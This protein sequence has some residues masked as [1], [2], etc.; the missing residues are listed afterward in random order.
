[1]TSSMQVQPKFRGLL[2]QLLLLCGIVALL[3]TVAVARMGR[4]DI[5]ELPKANGSGETPELTVDLMPGSLGPNGKPQ[6][7]LKLSQL[8]GKVVLIDMFASWCEHCKEH[9]PHMV[10]LYNEYRQRGFVVLG[11]A[12][13]DRSKKDTVANVK[14]FMTR[15]KINYTVGFVTNQVVAYFADNKNHGV[16]QMVLFGPDGKMVKRDIGWNARMEK[17][18]RDAIEAQL[19]KMPPAAPAKPAVPVNKAGAKVAPRK[20]K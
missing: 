6:R 20:T 12:T 18:I 8:R 19:A 9:A 11:L 4:E 17:P 14:G 15:A 13:D 7:T 3:S 2:R 1:M 16:P 10:Q 5:P